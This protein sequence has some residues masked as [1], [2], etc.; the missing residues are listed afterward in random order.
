MAV[1]QVRVAVGDGA[2]TGSAARV[3]VA[4]SGE[5]WLVEGA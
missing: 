4:A 3:V 2:V 1:G 5:A